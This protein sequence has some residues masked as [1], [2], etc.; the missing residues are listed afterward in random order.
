MNLF[1]L[2]AKISLDTKEFDKSIQNSTKQGHEMSNSVENISGK[3]KK[4]AGIIGGLAIGKKVADITNS[5]VKMGIEGNASLETSITSWTTLL[6]TQ[7]EAKKMMDDITNYAAK[8]PFSKAGVDAMAKQLKN[9]GFEGQNL[10]DQL[11]KFGN[12]G[13][14]FGI[15]EDS[16]K[17]M[18]R[19]YGQVQMAQIAYT[20][21]LNILQDRGIPI[22]KALSEVIGGTV[23]DVKKM[24]SEG[25]ISA[26]IY[27]EAIDSIASTTEGAMEAQSKT[28]SGMMSTLRDVTTNITTKIVEPLFNKVKDTLD[29]VM[30]I[31]DTFNGKLNEGKSFWQ[32]LKE[33]VDEMLPQFTP[34][35]ERLEEVGEVIQTAFSWLMD[36]KDEIIAGILGIGTAMAVFKMSNLILTMV[37]AMKKLNKATLMAKASQWLLNTVLWANPIGVVIGLI[38]GLVAGVI[39]L[40]NTNEDFANFIN[41]SWE[42]IKLLAQ[43][44]WGAIVTFFTET[45][46]NA[47]NSLVEFF[48]GIPQWFADLWNSMLETIKDWGENVSNFFTETIPSWIENIANWFGEIPYKIGYALGSA[49]GT[50]VKWG[51]D[52]WNY[53]VTSIPIWI[54]NIS[55]WFAELP[56]EI[57][58]WLTD[59]YNKIVEWGSNTVTKAK[60]IGINFLES[61]INSVKELPSK[62]W[63]WLSNTLAK[64]G[65][66]ASDL[67]RKAVEAG[68]NLVDN[69]VNTIKNLPNEMFNIGKN[70]VQGVWNGI[71]SMGDWIMGK[72]K[73]FFKGIVNGAK[74][75][76]GIHSPSRVFRDEVGKYMAEG[77]AVGFENEM[78][79]V[80]ADI[81]KILN[82]TVDVASNIPQIETQDNGIGK[83]I[84]LLEALLNKDTTIEI[85]GRTV[86]KALAP[87][88][89][90][91][92][93][94]DSR[95]IQF[96]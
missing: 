49:L 3:F 93:R 43:D 71:T 75:V 13:S 88:K 42:G 46:P 34:I 66:F 8:T 63:N 29:N 5:I 15:Q 56:G 58:A 53:L 4:L 37:D 94:F 9:A 83:V 41:T 80:N 22:Y 64:V 78:S 30:P 89:D 55:N 7:E 76:L 51:I 39:Y 23:A 38:A 1:N 45:I 96:A 77:V 14:A 84:A 2:M 52:T 92:N 60:E 33:T 24:A 81:E 17:E 32:S 31:L 6:G 36:N 12:M 79:T 69:I 67:G 16:L 65:Q 70:I 86:G 90:E 28:F 82:T 21:D 54:E 20:E 91:I 25:K 47:W 85:D 10:F 59:T 87:Y 73:G 26:D 11:T 19:Q 61:I 40:Y 44:V 27:N 48:K 68:R 35:I 50:I 18:V 74:S 57:W 62:I 95:N 72:V